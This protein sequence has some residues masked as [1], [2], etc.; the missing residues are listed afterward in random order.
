[1]DEPS[2]LASRV[3]ALPPELFNRIY[4]GTFKIDFDT[5]KVNKSHKPPARLQV[6][7]A[8][9]KEFAD[10][11]YSETTFTFGNRVTC[12]KWLKGIPRAHRRL[13]KRLRITCV[14]AS[15]LIRMGCNYPEIKTFE[16]AEIQASVRRMIML[17]DHIPN[18]F[19]DLEANGIQIDPAVLGFE[20][21]M[22]FWGLEDFLID[23]NGN[24]KLAVFVVSVQSSCFE[25][26][27]HSL[28][29]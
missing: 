15:D 25:T 11:Y 23:C 26:N 17:H 3:Q 5:C 10:A 21:C 1:M 8:T 19:R 13:L 6:S 9:R 20:I 22:A 4:T 29:I 27:L 2:N 28:C 24:S 18:T 7:Q 14:D 16:S 12:R